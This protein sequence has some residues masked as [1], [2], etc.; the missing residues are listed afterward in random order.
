MASRPR[1]MPSSPRGR[2]RGHSSTR[3][4]DSLSQT[5][6]ASRALSTA[7]ITSGGS[8]LLESAPP[9][10]RLRGCEALR[11]C[12]GTCAGTT[13]LRL[14]HFISTANTWCGV[15]EGVWLVTG[16][17]GL[18]GGNAT[19][20]ATAFLF[21]TSLDALRERLTIPLGLSRVKRPDAT[22][23]LQQG[24]TATAARLLIAVELTNLAHQRHRG[25]SNRDS[26]A[27]DTDPTL[28]PCNAKKGNVFHRVSLKL[29]FCV[30]ALY[31]PW[32]NEER[33]GPQ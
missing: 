12:E 20:A 4:A 25:E 10:V 29:A 1:G 15:T 17:V 18:V 2:V 28:Q 23:A 30:S 33:D 16:K 14:V 26:G 9:A 21:S 11:L 24:G 22:S 19:T 7:S 32:R 31:P 8:P 13:H 6:N 5:A 3:P 27:C